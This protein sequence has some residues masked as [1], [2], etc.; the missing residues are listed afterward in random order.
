MKNASQGDMAILGQIFKTDWRP[1]VL[2]AYQI[3]LSASLLHHSTARI[4]AVPTF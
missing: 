1:E 4:K 2:E 3:Q